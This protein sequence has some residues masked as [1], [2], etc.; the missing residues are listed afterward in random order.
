MKKYLRATS[1]LIQISKD[2]DSDEE[3]S[4]SEKSF[5]D[6]LLAKFYEDGNKIGS[7]ETVQLPLAGVCG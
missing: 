7:Q 6:S 5:S 3:G 4:S 2:I 1:V